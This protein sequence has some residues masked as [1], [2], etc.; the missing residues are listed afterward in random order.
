A[1]GPVARLIEETGQHPS[2]GTI[3]INH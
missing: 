3:I 1:P 2:H